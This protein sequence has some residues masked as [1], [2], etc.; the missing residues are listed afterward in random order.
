MRG[1]TFIELVVTLGVMAILSWLALPIIETQHVRVK[2]TELRASLREIRQAID[3]FK[4]ASDEGRIERKLEDTGYPR[5]LEE[6]VQGVIDVKDPLG[7]RIYFMR[8]LPRDPFLGDATQWGQRSYR[9]APENPKPG[10]DIYDVYSLS[11]GTGLNG[12]PYKKW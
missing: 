11:A 2:E 12:I 4:K 1:F 7:R 10:P 5:T 8:S 3:L 6:L 9:S